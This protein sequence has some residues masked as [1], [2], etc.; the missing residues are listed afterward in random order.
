[1]G[2]ILS[3]QRMSVAEMSNL[4]THIFN[5][6][7]VGSDYKTSRPTPRDLLPPTKFHKVTKFPKSNT[8]WG[9]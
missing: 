3:W 4:G 8:S 9:I 2:C 6:Q 7:E 1:M 5:E